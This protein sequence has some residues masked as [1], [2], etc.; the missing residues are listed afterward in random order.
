MADHDL[1]RLSDPLLEQLRTSPDPRVRGLVHVANA[2][3][4]RVVKMERQRELSRDLKERNEITKGIDYQLGVQ[5]SAVAGAVALS[6]MQLSVALRV[7]LAYIASRGGREFEGGLSLLIGEFVKHL[8]G[9][10]MVGCPRLDRHPGCV[11]CDD[12][13]QVPERVLTLWKSLGPVLDVV[14]AP[15]APYTCDSDGPEASGC[16]DP[17]TRCELCPRNEVARG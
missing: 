9:G 11:L 12:A 1:E 17:N 8:D 14:L 7:V 16:D 13:A 2:A 6:N 5:Q 15:A 3:A 10:P 4:L